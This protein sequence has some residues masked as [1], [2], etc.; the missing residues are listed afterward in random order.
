MRDEITR[1]ADNNSRWVTQDK[2]Y[3]PS[4]PPEVCTGNCTEAALASILGIRLDQVPSFQGLVSE[5]YWDAV[6][7]FVNSR[8]FDLV[9]N[10]RA[11]HYPGLYLADGPSP[12]G[13]GHFVVMHD[14][15]MIHDPHP[16]RAG[17]LSI[18]KTWALI[19]HDPASLA[20][21]TDHTEDKLGMVPEGWGIEQHN[22]GYMVNPPHGPGCWVSGRDDFNVPLAD[23]ALAKLCAA[24]LA[25]APQPEGLHHDL[26]KL[27]AAN[28]MLV[29]WK[30]EIDSWRIAAGLEFP[31]DYDNSPR[32]AVKSLIDHHA[33]RAPDHSAGNCIAAMSRMKDAAMVAHKLCYEAMLK[34]PDVETL[35]DDGELHKA[36]HAIVGVDT[37]NYVAS[38]DRS[39]DVRVSL[40]RKARELLAAE[41]ARDGQAFVADRIRTDAMLTHVED[42]SLRAIVA[43]LAQPADADSEGG[44]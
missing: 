4:Q 24:M 1:L 16:S 11:T 44:K 42:R 6:Y 41:Y 9:M 21:K 14:G 33:N 35:G 34:H 20:S 10:H 2:F 30:G 26:E 22:G 37:P 12:R 29:R 5:D 8:G 28:A 18:E 39:A 38:P 31:D 23:Q 43:A 7:A 40:H 13:C 36:I 27:K 15:E 25:A 32:Y 17:L 3:D 19:P